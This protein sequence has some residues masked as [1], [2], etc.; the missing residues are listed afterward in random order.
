VEKAGGAVNR[1]LRRELVTEADAALPGYAATR[2]A[3]AERV[4]QPTQALL[5]GRNLF[6]KTGLA[7]EELLREAPLGTQDAVR[8]LRIGALD[9]ARRAVGRVPNAKGTAN[10]AGALLR[11]DDTERGLRALSGNRARLDRLVGALEGEQR[12]HETFRM[13]APGTGSRTAILQQAGEQADEASRVVKALINRSPSGMLIEQLS[14]KGRMSAPVAEQIVAR[15]MKAQPTPAEL[16]AML[17]SDQI[18]FE[19][20]EVL[21]RHAT[22][23]GAGGGAAAASLGG[24]YLDPGR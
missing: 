11:T 5:A 1:D 3:W 2:R 23:W 20:K 7:Q 8:A 12:M 9:S 14:T 22:P 4:R 21:R 18:P 15:L 13:L 6:Q 17:S 24:G 16:N 19:V 10:L